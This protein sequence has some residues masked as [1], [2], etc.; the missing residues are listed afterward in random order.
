[1]AV[2]GGAWRA[3]ALSGACGAAR[4]SRSVGAS[5]VG[6]R[7]AQACR[8][9]ARRGGPGEDWLGLVRSGAVGSGVAWRSWHGQ[10]WR[11]ELCPGLAAEAG[12]VLAGRGKPSSGGQG[13]AGRGLV[14]PGTEG[15]VW[16]SCRGKSWL[17]PFRLDEP[18]RSWLGWSWLGGPS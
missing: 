1:M 5:F 8:G 17:G 6:F 18:W 15:R 9:A 16:R 13:Q 12:L 14:R 11:A 7:Q 4:R 3:T 2:R 10:S